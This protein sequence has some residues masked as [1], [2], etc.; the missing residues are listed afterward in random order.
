[1][2]V[3]KPA[4][5]VLWV[6]GDEAAKMTSPSAPKR[7][8]GW[9]EGEK[10]AFQTMN[11]LQNNWGKW[12]NYVDQMPLFVNDDTDNNFGWGVD[13]LDGLIAGTD[14]IAMGLEAAKDYNGSHGTFYG[15]KA[16]S[17][18]EDSSA[19]LATCI[20]YRAG[21]V[22][23]PA[24]S[25]DNGT[26]LGALSGLDSQG[27]SQTCVGAASGQDNNNDHLIA[28]GLYSADGAAHGDKSIFIGYDVGTGAT[29][30]VESVVWIG[31]S[32]TSTPLIQ[33]SFTNSL[34][35]INGD[36]QSTGYIAVEDG[37]TAPG[38]VSGKAL[39]YVDTADGDL[40]VKFGNGTVKTIATDT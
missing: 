2:T 31:D 7:V 3:A 25:S 32:N 27:H 18:R 16:A 24:V 38:T 10:P 12:G 17:G 20:G 40:K 39:I 21:E 34:L 36:L 15:H 28:I 35:V 8:L 9:I 23:S 4:D 22:S 29:L 13:V 1:M 30:G 5:L 37:M 14:N 33:G 6:P 19:G 11:Y 26:Y